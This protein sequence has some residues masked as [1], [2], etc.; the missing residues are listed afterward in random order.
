[1]VDIVTQIKLVQDLSVDTY[2]SQNSYKVVW[3]C[4]S[5]KFLDISLLQILN[6]NT[7]RKD[8]LRLMIMRGI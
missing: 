2:I 1:M 6:A 7:A 4:S 3:L 8:L 5:Q